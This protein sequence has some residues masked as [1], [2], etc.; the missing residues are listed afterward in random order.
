[1]L[2]KKTLTF[3]LL[4]LSFF[5][6]ASMAFD[7]SDKTKQAA[8]LPADLEKNMQSFAGHIDPSFVIEISQEREKSH[9]DER[10]IESTKS[11]F[12]EIENRNFTNISK[13]HQEN[14]V[15]SSIKG[16][17][18]MDEY[19]AEL[20]QYSDID[21]GEALKIFESCSKVD[22]KGFNDLEALY[23]EALEAGVVES[24]F[25]L[26]VLYPPSFSDSIYWL[27]RSATWNEES[28]R[29]LSETVYSSSA[30][31]V[32]KAFWSYAFIGENNLR[33]IDLDNHIATLEMRLNEE[34]RQ[35]L[36]DLANSW[37]AASS[38][39]ERRR[40]IKKLEAL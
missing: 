36:I 13:F 10:P 38:E 19:L 34:T 28:I 21:I 31:D 20:G 35:V 33:V 11:L 9:I 1:M 16:F 8:G 24:E 27:S 18:N 29:L 22:I 26:G 30:S 25:L 12:N 6:S 15:C 32:Y 5:L 37:G 3:V 4:A 2:K 40:I 23:F 39:S 14:L 7:S 17:S